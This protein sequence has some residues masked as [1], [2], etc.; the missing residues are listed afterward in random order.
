MSR[1]GVALVLAAAAIPASG[2]GQ[3][4]SDVAGKPV[5]GRKGSDSN[6]ATS[7]GFPA[8]ATKNTTRV[9]GA[10]PTADAGAVALAVFSGELDA[11]RPR[12]ITLVDRADWQSGVAASVFMSPTVRAPVLLSDGG[13]L[14]GGTRDVFGTLK[15]SGS[16]KLGGAQVIRVGAVGAPSGLRTAQVAPG[17]P[18]AMALAID[19]LQTKAIGK[20]SDSVVVASGE[21]AEFAMPAAGWAAKSGDP[22]L[23][24]T[25]DAIPPETRAALAFHQQPKIYLLGPPDV[26]S[27]KTEKALRRLGTVK[28]I[29]GP[30]AVTNA[31]AFARYSD[32]PFGWDVVD[33]GH[34]LV[35]ASSTRPL[36]AAAAAPLSASGK[37][38]PL[39]LVDEAGKLP[40][41]L[42]QF[43]LDIQP[44]Y[45]KDPVRGVYNHA[46]L[47]GDSNTISLSDQ[48]RID[49]LLEIA[50]V[51]S[52][53]PSAPTPSGPAKPPAKSTATPKGQAPSKGKTP[54]K[55]SA[56]T[57][58]QPTYKVP[59]KL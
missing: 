36:D 20:P 8:F 52:T 38:G 7:L 46:W 40:A 42:V 30:D 2:C 24:V 1:R 59:R 33:P 31:I 57:T 11:A 25:R 41:P 53:Q 14:P 50:P 12:A 6:A 35:V 37:Y 5:I 54:T 51:A 9:G 16:S 47:V 34:G 32:G 18:F 49:T 22:V 15:P 23:Y 43:L 55:G 29:A 17:N 28:R 19:Q 13:S 3:Q 26:I 58:T 56:P 45:E 27:V 21:R 10:D 4:S 39:L 44:G 48:A